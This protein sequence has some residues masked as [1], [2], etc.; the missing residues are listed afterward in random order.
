M[1]HQLCSFAELLTLS[2]PVNA[3]VEIR[4]CRSRER[5]LGLFASQRITAG[6]KILSE[7]TF[8]VDETRDDMIAGI[9]HEFATMPLASQALF[10][11]LFAGRHD[12]VPHMEFGPDRDQDSVSMAR[13]QQIVRLNSIEGAGIGCVISPAVSGINHD[14]IPNAYA[15]YN[16]ETGVVAV[17]ALQVI[18]PGQEVTISYLQDDV[19]LES[20]ERQDRLVN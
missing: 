7:E 6:L 19:Y 10:T 4:A 13:L 14:C 12:M 9:G 11:R 17:H 1:S 8:L 16:S 18:Q 3:N 20:G 15:Y 5:G 2:Y